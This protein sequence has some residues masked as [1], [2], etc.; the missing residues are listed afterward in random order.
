MA[1][2]IIFMGTPNFCLPILK[3]IKDSK[4]NLLAIYTQTPKKKNRG[5][6]ITFSPVH[7]FANKSK[8]DVR[9]PEEINTDIEIKKILD[10]KP[11]VVVVV[12]YGKILPQKLLNTKKVKFINVHASL[13]P[14]WRGAAPIHRSIMSLDKETGISIM[15]IEP[16]LDSGP[17]M[18]SDKVKIS[19][20]TN[21]NDL[22]ERLS[23]LG[24]KLI[25]ESLNLIEK[26]KEIFIQQNH[27]KATY[28]KKITKL[29][30]KIDWNYEASKIIGKINALNP[31]P[32]SWFKLRGQRIKITKAIEIVATGKP[33]EIIKE[34]FTIACSKNAVQILELIKEGK[35][36]VKVDEF[37]KGNK[38]S[39]GEN[40]N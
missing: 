3:S 17:V 2:K 14:K 27:K 32:G 33:G 8:I 6:K 40:I 30:S 29:E 26:G 37:L 35:S 38:I 31:N 22:S 24:A 39:I 25:I 1:L 5:Q 13:L 16:K 34:N 9:H 10:L 12:A 4:H 15:K 20:D 19:K 36:K 28:A 21:Y 11:D 18:M 23:N 7:N